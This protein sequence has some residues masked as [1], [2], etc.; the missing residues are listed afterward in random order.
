MENKPIPAYLDQDTHNLLDLLKYKTK[1]TK[2]E[3]IR[4]ACLSLRKTYRKHL[5]EV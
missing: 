2:T 1:K 5:E 4:Q 3:L